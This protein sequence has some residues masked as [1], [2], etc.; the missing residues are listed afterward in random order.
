MAPVNRNVLKEKDVKFSV[1]T[2]W[3]LTMLPTI[4]H[5]C[6]HCLVGVMEVLVK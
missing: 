5:K 1:G 3:L 6:H 4:H 2:H